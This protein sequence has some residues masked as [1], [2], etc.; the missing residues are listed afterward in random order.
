MSSF[1]HRA[2]LVLGAALLL[3]VAT[4]FATEARAD[5]LDDIRARGVLRCAVSIDTDD[6]SLFDAHG[7]VSRFGADLCRAVAAA[8]FAS[9]GKT[10]I[11]G[12]GDEITAL[13]AVRDRHAD[14]AF[15]TTP[16]PALASQLSLIYAQPFLIDGQGFLVN[17]GENIADIAALAGKRICFVEG[18]PE[19]ATLKTAM[20]ERGI[21]FTA[22][23][24]SER[25]EMMAA[26]ATGHCNA[27]TGDVTELASERLS[28]PALARNAVLLP[29]RITVDPWSPVLRDDEQRLRAI[30]DVVEDGLVSATV[31]GID[32]N[33][34]L[35]HDTHPPESRVGRLLGSSGWQ[36]KGLGLDEPFLRR[37][38]AAIGNQAE[39]YRRD[40]GDA[41]PLKLP[42]GPNAPL[43]KGGALL[44]IPV[45]T[46]R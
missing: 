39:F 34:A 9:G 38:I 27:V 33:E 3:S 15:G 7:N 21:G 19:G 18:S 26:L 1:A 6:F 12:T 30:V 43:E 46:S 44:S 22:F 11:T 45:S 32:R 10:E 40:L 5:A 25:G 20:A 13:R 41:S 29:E 28:L 14:I 35:S 36:A 23:P 2:S 8:I 24:F 42:V 37:A 17:S 31:L 16:D 4:A